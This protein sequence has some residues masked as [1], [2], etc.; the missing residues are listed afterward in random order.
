MEDFR[1]C[2][3]S[4]FMQTGGMEDINNMGMDDFHHLMEYLDRKSKIE[5]GKPVR[6]RESNREMIRRAKVRNR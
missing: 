5:E 2:K 4:I 3:Y 1:S 6:L